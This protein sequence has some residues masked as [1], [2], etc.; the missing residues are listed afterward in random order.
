VIDGVTVTVDAEAVV[1]VAG[2]ALDVV[3]SAPVGGGV[4][5]AR[6]LVNLHVPLDFAASDLETPIE[7]LA[8]A[9]ALPPPWVG[10]LTAAATD[11]AEIAIA[12]AADV[13]ALAV[14]TVGLSHPIAAGRAEDYASASSVARTADV[15]AAARAHGTINAIVIVDAAID[16]AGLVNAVATVA[17]VKAEMLAAAGVRCVDGSVAT[18]TATDAVAVA[19]TGRGSRYR[20]AGPASVPGAAIARAARTALTRGVDRWLEAHR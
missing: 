3:S 11:R 10:F 9:R 2:E 8:R 16:H 15:A 12:R 17:E 18:G 7:R 1:V 14:V 19:A 6:S 20:F 13:I 4:V 5:R